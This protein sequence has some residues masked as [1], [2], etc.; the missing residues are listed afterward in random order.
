MFALELAMGF[1]VLA[2]SSASTII[3]SR[4]PTYR[5]RSDSDRQHVTPALT[6]RVYRS[7]EKI[8]IGQRA[9]E[10]IAIHIAADA[11]HAAVV[12]NCQNS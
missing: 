3:H 1:S 10:S 8:P 7:Q 11:D 6:L 5:P 12:V 9:V 4:S 2:F